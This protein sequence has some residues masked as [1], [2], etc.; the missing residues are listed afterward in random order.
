MR[1]I[2]LEPSAAD[3]ITKMRNIPALAPLGDKLLTE[4]VGLSRLRKYAKDEVI[5]EE[6]A[7]DS[8]LYFLVLG[9]LSVEHQGVVVHTLKAFGEMFGEMGLID[10]SPRSAT[11]KAVASS[12]C[13][14][15]D[16]AL[17]SKLEPADRAALKAALNEIILAHMA[18][19]LRE[20]DRKLAER[21]PA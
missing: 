17:F 9:E 11:V 10:G 15:L 1:E 14:A 6:G 8:W 7:Q 4:V 21:G 19:R 3:I 18:E 16:A 2:P 13:L 20:M 5:I 12:V